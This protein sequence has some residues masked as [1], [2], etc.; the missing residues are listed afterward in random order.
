MIMK[1]AN[2]IVGPQL[3]GVIILLAGWIMVKYPPKKI[4]YLYGYRTE[5]SMKNQQTWDE[6]NRFSARLMVK[7]GG[8]LIALGLIISLIFSV[9]IL[10][11]DIEN[12]LRTA[13][14]FI[15]SI[16]SAVILIVGTQRHLEKTFPENK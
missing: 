9:G 12:I 16:V 2:W 1:I 8:V 7:I 14:L 6:A 10:R 13:L 15:S 11:S 3:I 4:N 5:L